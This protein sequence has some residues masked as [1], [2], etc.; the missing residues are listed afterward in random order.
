MK[1]KVEYDK[2]LSETEVVLRCNNMK[3]PEVNALLGYLQLYDGTVI[4]Y[5][6]GEAHKLFLYEV[7]YIDSVDEKT[8]LYLDNGVYETSKKLYEWESELIDTPFVRISKSTILNTD[9]LQSVRPTFSGKLEAVLE[10]GEKQI[11]NRHY[12]AGFRQKFGI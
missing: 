4:G 6:D 8:F 7:F 2:Q 3:D 1:I 12:V 11:V 9:K 5:K 10:N